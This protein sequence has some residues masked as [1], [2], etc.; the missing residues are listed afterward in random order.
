M[1]TKIFMKKFQLIALAIIGLYACLNLSS[2][3]K[4]DD[5]EKTSVSIVGTWKCYYNEYEGEIYTGDDI[6]YPYMIID[7]SYLGFSKTTSM[8]SAQVGGEKYQY[9]YNDKTMVVTLLQVDRT[10]N[11]PYGD[12][13]FEMQ[14][15]KLNS[16]ELW[17]EWDVN[18]GYELFKFKKN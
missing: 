18:G 2:C 6:D 9:S 4:D 10:D 5:D 15:T 13:S 14:I 12:P 11:E 7:N 3:K 1:R 16:S 8:P 17:F